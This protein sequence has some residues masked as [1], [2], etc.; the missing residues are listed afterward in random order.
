MDAQDADDTRNFVSDAVS[1]YNVNSIAIEV[2]ISM[3]TRTGTK[4]AATHVAAT[5]GS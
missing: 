2:P 1:G 4:V 5:I 3:L